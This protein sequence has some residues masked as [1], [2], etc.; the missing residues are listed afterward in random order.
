M[1]GFKPKDPV[2]LTLQEIML[3]HRDEP[4]T[5]ERAHADADDFLKRLKQGLI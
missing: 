4:K 1:R 2:E 5:M 3:E